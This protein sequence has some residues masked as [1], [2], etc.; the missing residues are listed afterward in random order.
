MI[1][2][3]SLFNE[4]MVEYL[5]KNKRYLLKRPSYLKTFAQI[6]SQIKKQTKVRDEYARE[7]DLIIPPVLIISVTNDCNLSCKGCYACSQNRD[8]SSEMSIDDIE[9]VV[10]EAVVLGVSVILIAGGEPLMKKGILNLPKKHKDILFVMFTNGLLLNETIIG[11]L[12][13][14]RNLIPIISIEGSEERTDERRGKGMFG[15]IMQVM[16]NLNRQ[17]ILFG[18]SITVT[19]KNYTEVVQSVYFEDM[20]SKG[21]RAVFLIEYV[22]TENDFDLCLTDEQKQD[23]IDQEELL[24]K[25]Y[26]MLFVPLPGNEDKYGGCLASGRGFL[27]ISSTGSLEACPF[28]PYSDTNVKDIPLKQALRSKLLKEIRENHHMLKES[29][30]GCALQENKEWIEQLMHK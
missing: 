8:H 29:R 15:S 9:R 17:K 5:I 24:S 6:S 12:R 16:E 23:L 4:S 1:Q 28:A 19:S 3:I 2:G 14:M 21:C 25:K 13:S 22:P 18:T 26:H 27:H 30:G 10:D 20:E 11:Q 7:Q